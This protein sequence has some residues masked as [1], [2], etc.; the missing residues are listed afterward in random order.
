MVINCKLLTLNVRGLNKEGKRRSVYRYIKTKN[1]DVCYLQE[2]YSSKG[3]EH[4]WKNQWGGQIYFSHGSNHAKGVMILIRPGF[5]IEVEKAVCDSEG[6]YILLHANINGQHVVMLNIYAPN[7][8]NEQIEFYNRIQT[9]LK[10]EIDKECAILI[11]G[12]MNLILDPCMDRKGGNFIASKMYHNVTDLFHCIMD[13]WNLCD[14][15][16]RKNPDI[17]RFTWRQKS[18]PIH[19]RLDM[20]LVSD[21]IQ[22]FCT[23]ID[24]W[25]SV[26]SDH[27]A[28]TLKLHNI[29]LAKGNGLWKLN[30]SYLQDDAYVKELIPQFDIWREESEILQDKRMTWEYIKYKVRDFSIKYGKKKKRETINTEKYL[31]QRL[32]DI[33]EE[34]DQ[35]DNEANFAAEKESIINKL[36]SIDNY[37]TEGLIL[38]TKSTWYE[39]GERS[40]K[41][42]LRLL[43]RNVI[44]TNMNKLCT[45][46]GIITNQQEILQKQAEFYQGLYSDKVNKTESEMSTYLDNVITP[47]ISEQDRVLCSGI[48]TYEECEKTLMMMKNNKTPGN[49][50]LTVEFYKKFW[51]EIGSLLVETFNLS[52]ECGQLSNSQRQAIIV[53]IDKGKDRTLLKNWRPISLLNVDYKLLSKT[54]AERLKRVLPNIIHT[55]QVG[56]I[57]G[58]NIVDNIRSLLDLLEYTKSYNLPGILINIDFEKAFDS[59]SWKFIEVVMQEKFKFDAAFIE[60]I[61]VLYNGACSCILNNGFTSKYFPLHRGVRQGDPLSPYIFILVAE[62][63]GCVVRQNHHIQGIDIEG[64]SLKLLQYAD[65]TNGI[66]LNLKSAKV[67]LDTVETFGQFSGL[68]LNKEKTEALWLGK[69]SKYHEKPLGI[70]WPEKPIRVLGAYVSYDYNECDKLNYEVKISKCQSLLNDWKGRSLSLLG[71]I[72]VIKTFIISQFLFVTSALV[73]PSKYVNHV[74]KMVISFLWGG[75]KSLVSK[76]VM[77]KRKVDGGLEVPDLAKMISVSNIKWIKRFLEDSTGYWKLFFVHFLRSCNLNINVLLPSNYNIKSLRKLQKLPE[78]YRN[79]LSDC[80]KYVDTSHSRKNFIW[81]N[82]NINIENKPVYYKD[83]Y[84]VG[85][86]NICDL[87]DKNRDIIPFKKWLLKGLGSYNWLRWCGLINAVK[88]ILPVVTEWGL[89]GMPTLV[90]GTKQFLE[91]TAKDIYMHICEKKGEN[92]LTIPRIANYVSISDSLGWENVYMYPFQFLTDS[93]SKEFQY[94]FLHDVVV[95]RYWLDKWKLVDTNLCRLCEQKI[96]NIDHMFWSCVFVEKFW[97]NFNDYMSIKLK[98]TV[99]MNDVFLGKNDIVTN[100]VIVNAK[101]YIYKSFLSERIPQ[102]D[103]FLHYMSNIIKIEEN[104]YKRKGKLSEW[105]HKWQ[106]FVVN[107]TVS[108]L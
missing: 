48:I 1:I 108:M 16:R 33:E 66:V 72:Q 24:I 50:G 28:V 18:P 46:S 42:F 19:S 101:R 47:S 104:M 71:K 70:N 6:R 85:I 21:H 40:N 25:P 2:T 61:K 63:L 35:Y 64:K 102:L 57:K 22:D 38:R 11:A 92:T 14:L 81:Y 54:I 31:E 75:G 12:D 17:K 77:Y 83:F 69:C 51:K 27:S 58:R 94:K 73:M 56:F 103:I 55:D 7:I 98:I 44:K 59:V 68:L 95:N 34:I 32:R 88:D 93:K 29:D 15:W 53:L 105:K 26:R 91:C 65:D 30:N 3:I 52:Y 10:D 82:Q 89:H 45:D 76:E 13:E 41:Y 80:I 106:A 39:E 74:N 87:Y 20:W 49:D 97:N 67:F 78:F 60:W 100:T 43:S 86:Y 23:E 79:V 36:K 107:N 9:L 4:F 84:N 90:I 8:E 62:V 37:R 99:N 96:E 5:N